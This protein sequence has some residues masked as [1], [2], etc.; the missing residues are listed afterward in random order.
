MCGALSGQRAESC[1]RFCSGLAEFASWRASGS[2]RR[3][4]LWRRAT[5][6]EAALNRREFA[7]SA[8]AWMFASAS[9][10]NAWPYFRKKKK[11]Q[12]AAVAVQPAAPSVSGA[13]SLRAHGVLAGLPVG[14]AVIPEILDLDGAQAGKTA[15]P[16]TRTVLDQAGILVAEN[17]MKWS[18]LRP[19]PSGYSFAASD[20]LFDFARIGGQLVRGH[21]LC[22][23]EQLPAWFGS[24]A[25]P[26]NAGTESGDHIDERGLL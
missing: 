15:D 14:C 2:V 13:D 7:A 25:T 18:A 19:T 21:N 9:T 26:E 16:Y 6:S 1:W 8:A 24:V 20:R 3:E 23:H 10:P 4:G 5:E 11:K 12:P 17:A 22:W